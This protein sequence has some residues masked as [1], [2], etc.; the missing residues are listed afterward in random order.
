MAIN[1]AGGQADDHGFAFVDPAERQASNGS[2]SYYAFDARP[3]LRLI[4][5]NTVGEG[6][7]IGSEGNLDDPQF[8]WLTREL[9]AAQKAGKLVIV[10]GHH[11]IRSLSNDTADENA[12][13]CGSGSPHPGCDADPRDSKPLHL[14]ADLQAL[15]LAHPTAI[16]YVAGHTH[17]HRV[18]PFR[19]AKGSGF[20]GI[21]TAS[22]TDW[23]IQSRLLE[24][25]DN[26][27]GT[28]SIFGTVLDHGAQLPT[29]PSGTPAAGFDTETLAAIGRELSFNDPQAGGTTGL[30]K[31]EDRNVELL[32]DDP[33][34]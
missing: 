9:D 2:A 8:R 25:M 26:K 14:G 24:V 31:L 17:E 3:G 29:P 21:E 27:D 33:R 7:N 5:I 16:A 6:S 10:F 23:P 28:L 20:W 32:L 15:L 13:A 1:A 22:E 30:G 34:R 11:P 12:P 19:G 18:T 4:S